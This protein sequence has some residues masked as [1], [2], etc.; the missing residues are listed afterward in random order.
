VD[1]CFID[2]PLAV[3]GLNASVVNSNLR[4]KTVKNRGF[5]VKI[6]VFVD[7]SISEE[8]LWKLGRALYNELVFTKDLYLCE[9]SY[10]FIHNF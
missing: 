10:T 5:S 6:P 2:R 9:A 4:E 8:D 3:D 7:H 1:R